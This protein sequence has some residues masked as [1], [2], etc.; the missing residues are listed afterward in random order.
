MLDERIAR[1]FFA[2]V[3]KLAEW[4]GLVSDEH[5]SIEEIF[6][7]AKTV[8]GLRKTR[9]GSVSPVDTALRA[10][11]RAHKVPAAAFCAPAC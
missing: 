6:G 8:S 9:G 3:L 10:M 4:K 1:S 2:K 11:C 7:W 5:F